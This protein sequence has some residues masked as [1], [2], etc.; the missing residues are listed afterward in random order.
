[1]TTHD[2][3]L[4]QL[5]VILT[6]KQELLELFERRYN[7]EHQRGLSLELENGRLNK[8][9]GELTQRIG[10]LELGRIEI[11]SVAE[12]PAAEELPPPARPMRTV[13]EKS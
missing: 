10:E 7:H 8:R 2:T 6:E 1:M 12:Q 5:Q 9:I 3:G 13:K 4:Q 11:E